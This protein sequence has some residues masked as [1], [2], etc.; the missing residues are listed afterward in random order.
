MISN[1]SS[2][3]LMNTMVQLSQAQTAYQ[4]AL[5]SGVKIMNLSILNYI[6]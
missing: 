4:A 5:Q 6:S 3:D 2:A 1:S